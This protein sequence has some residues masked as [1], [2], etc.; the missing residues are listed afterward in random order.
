MEVGTYVP[1]VV[2]TIRGIAMV[3]CAEFRYDG[4]DVAGRRVFVSNVFHQRAGSRSDCSGARDANMES[5][6][7]M[8]ND[9]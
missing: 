6:G 3:G 7:T 2:G 1:K 5:R 8:E 4:A 9:V